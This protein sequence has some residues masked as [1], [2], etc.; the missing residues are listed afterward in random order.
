[1]FL[2]PLFPFLFV[3]RDF[4][5]FE[6]GLVSFHYGDSGFG[7]MEQVC[8]KRFNSLVSETIA[9]RGID[10]EQPNSVN[11]TERFLLSACFYLN[12]DFH[13]SIFVVR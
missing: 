3:P 11:K 4:N 8:Q 5:G 9:G 6:R 13:R 7:Q 1:M 10:L 12:A 2:L